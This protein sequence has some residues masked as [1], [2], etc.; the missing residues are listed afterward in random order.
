MNARHPR[1]LQ[2]MQSIGLLLFAFG[3]TA[4][5]PGNM[6]LDS[7]AILV[8]LCLAVRLWIEFNIQADEADEVLETQLKRIGYL[9][10]LSWMLAGFGVLAFLREQ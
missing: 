2:R 10:Q 1:F 7:T 6:L 5:F 8:T 9:N 4:R 3:L